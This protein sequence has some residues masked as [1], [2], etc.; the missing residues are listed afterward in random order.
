MARRVCSEERAWIE[1]L[2]VGG[3]SDAEIAKRLG[4]DRSTVWRGKKC[5]GAGAYCAVGAHAGADAGAKRP[6]ALKLAA[7]AGL[8][9]EVQQ[10]LD[11]RLSPHAISAE[12]APLGQFVCAETIYRLYA[13]KRGLG[14]LW[15]S[16]TG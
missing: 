8:R 16:A 9:R 12:L 11:E 13:L 14:C 5:C 10:R 4:R 15:G 7:D 1:V 2:S 3:F 6:R